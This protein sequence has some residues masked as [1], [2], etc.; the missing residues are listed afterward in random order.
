MEPR[1]VWA[2]SLLAILIAAFAVFVFNAFYNAPERRF[3]RRLRR[4]AAERARIGEQARQ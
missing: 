3:E 2:Y 4:V 1:L